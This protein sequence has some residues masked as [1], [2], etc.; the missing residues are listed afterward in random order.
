MSCPC[1]GWSVRPR[2]GPPRSHYQ[3][4]GISP[5]ERD[6]AAIEEAALALTAQ[7]R[8]YQITHPDE[9]SRLLNDIAHALATLLDPGQ[10]AE[11]DAALSLPP[12]AGGTD[13]VAWAGACPAGTDRPHARGH[14]TLQLLAEERVV[15][16]LVDPTSPERGRPA[17][18]KRK[19][20]RPWVLETWCVPPGGDAEFVWRMEDLIRTYQLPYDPRHP[21]VCLAV[22]A[23]ELS[24]GVPQSPAPAPGGPARA[25][26]GRSASCHLLLACEP[27]RGWRQVQVIERSMPRDYARRLWELVEV[28]YPRARKIRLVQDDLGLPGG[29]SLYEV[30]P[31]REARRL[32]GKVEFHCTPRHGRWLNLARTE[33]NL[34]HRYCLDR[35]LDSAG[36][37]A[38]E[39]AVWERER[40]ARKARIQWTFTFA[41]AHRKLRKLY[42]SPEEERLP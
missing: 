18:G 23:M 34:L 11:Y 40:N 32:L 42:P 27:L 3:L 7:V 17:E 37:L 10:R 31:P 13:A 15:L 35:G 14:W 1:P 16:A 22:A 33:V 2:E 28:R 8:A 25:D 39:A 24:G 21:V 20:P 6:L 38:E 19:D 4:L 41:A 36:R 5:N 29:A 9:C 30:F 12:A 26:D